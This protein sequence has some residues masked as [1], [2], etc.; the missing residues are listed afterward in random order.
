MRSVLRAAAIAFAALGLV[1]GCSESTGPKVGPRVTVTMHVIDLSGPEYL[2]T[3]G[4]EQLARCVARIQAQAS[5]QGEVQWTGYTLRLFAGPDRTVPV[6]TALGGLSDAM[7]AWGWSTIP[8]GGTADASIEYALNLPFSLEIEFRY[9]QVKGVH[10]G[11][12]SSTKTTVRCES[13][14]ENPTPPVLSELEVAPS[15]FLQPGAPVVLRYRA[16]SGAG[17]WESAY[18]LSAPSCR[19]EGA[20]T[21]QAPASPMRNVHLVLPWHCRAGDTLTYRVA[22]LD[23]RGRVVEA[24]YPVRVPIVDEVAPTVVPT[25]SIQDIWLTWHLAPYGDHFE[26]DSLI[27]NLGATDNGAMDYAYLQNVTAGTSDTVRVAGTAP[28]VRRYARLLTESWV[29]E[30]AL[31]VGARDLAGNRATAVSFPAGAFRVHP[32]RKVVPRTV[33]LGDAPSRDLLVA[34]SHNLAVVAR[35]FGPAVVVDLASAAIVRNVGLPEQQDDVRAVEL[36]LDESVLFLAGAG[37]R[38]YELPLAAPLSALTSRAVPTLDSAGPYRITAMRVTS[39]GSMVL[40]ALNLTTGRYRTLEWDRTTN[41]VT[42]L[43]SAATGSGPIERSPDGTRLVL[44]SGSECSVRWVV[45][46]G[47]LGEP[48]CI[49]LT[50][51]AVDPMQDRF[52]VR[53]ELYTGGSGRAEAFGVPTSWGGHFRAVA[54]HPSG[55]SVVMATSALNNQWTSLVRTRLSDGRFIDR[56]QYPVYHDRV[57]Y[58]ADGRRVVTVGQMNGVQVLSTFVW[59]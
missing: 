2:T 6:D 49:L 13:G 25:F 3:P 40:S 18:L 48:A 22:A 7:A 57:A 32:T 21:E 4:G 19:L 17:I 34:G 15:S 9:R 11:E 56:V 5:G 28:E 51:R 42:D 39:R 45:A 58:A 10:E 35:N 29:G 24:E 30:P 55:E 27:L 59:P 31:T 14:E 33:P 54:F 50:Q 46:T 23:A 38:V 41:A 52:A 1:L 53:G 12:E 16:T 43:P 26:G 44:P 37:G 8:A 36:S 20:F 47:A